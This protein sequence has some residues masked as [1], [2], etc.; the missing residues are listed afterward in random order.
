MQVKICS[1]RA[2]KSC[3]W[4]GAGRWTGTGWQA[5]F[6]SLEQAVRSRDVEVLKKHLRN[7]VPEYQG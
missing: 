2:M 3:S 5:E 6:A 7:I 1:R 4:P